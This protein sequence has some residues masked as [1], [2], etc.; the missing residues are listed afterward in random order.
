MPLHSRAAPDAF[1]KGEAF[2]GVSYGV[3]QVQG[4]ADA[5]FLRVFFYDVFLTCT[6]RPTMDFSKA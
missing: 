3:P 5:M 2:E 1:G 6:E 4:F